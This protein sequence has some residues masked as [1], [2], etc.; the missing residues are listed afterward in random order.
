MSKKLIAVASAAALAL[1]ALVGVAPA[2]ANTFVVEVQNLAGTAPAQTAASPAITPSG[3]TAAAAFNINVPSSN[4]IRSTTSTGTSTAALFIVT[5]TTSR[6]QVDVTATGG[7]KLIT[8]DQLAASTTTV[9]TGTSSLTDFSASS[10]YEFYAINTSTT[11]GTVVISNAGNSKT[12]YLAG[13]STFA[14]KLNLTSTASAALGGKII[15][16][17]TVKDAFGNDLTSPYVAA[18]FVTS[19][20]GATAGFTAAFTGSDTFLYTAATKTYSWAFTAPAT[21]TPVAVQVS[22]FNGTTSKTPVSVTAFGTPVTTAFFTVN[23]VDLVTRVAALEAQ[24]AALT[25][26]YNALAA[27]WNKRVASKKA[28]KK[29]VATK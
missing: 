13:V 24:V 5:T 15:V 27:K 28:P 19:T 10:K 18:D 26:D 12:V 6:G 14:Y 3:I 25:A 9:A 21:A 23:A 22:M 1:S 2:N 8:A 17:G 29:A 20:V 7:V 11:A 4:V 16:S